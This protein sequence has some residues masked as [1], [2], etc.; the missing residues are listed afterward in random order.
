MFKF[1][2]RQYRYINL[3]LI[4]I[5]PTLKI[6]WYFIYRICFGILRAGYIRRI[7]VKIYICVRINIK[8]W[9]SFQFLLMKIKWRQKTTPGKTEISHQVN[10]SSYLHYR[11]H[12]IINRFLN[13][14]V[15]YCKISKRLTPLLLFTFHV[16]SYYTSYRT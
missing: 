7:F 2:I 16:T 9:R 15:K 5:L 14:N 6:L 8:Q 12:W 10:S 4:Q 3:F 11:S 13:E 1:F